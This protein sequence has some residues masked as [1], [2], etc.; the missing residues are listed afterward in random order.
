M[1][2]AHWSLLMT[3]SAAKRSG[4]FKS[5]SVMMRSYSRDVMSSCSAE[6]ARVD[7]GLKRERVFSE[8]QHESYRDLHNYTLTIENIS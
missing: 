5:R 3:L 4:P 2:A 7:P 1:R 8:G 6:F